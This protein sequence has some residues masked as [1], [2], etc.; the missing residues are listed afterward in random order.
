MGSLG[1]L[2]VFIVAF[3]VVFACYRENSIAGKY[4]KKKKKKKK[5][6]PRKDGKLLTLQLATR[7]KVP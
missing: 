3:W 5:E 6:N 1:C 2:N 7:L 4:F